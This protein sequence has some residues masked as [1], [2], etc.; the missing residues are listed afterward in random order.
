MVREVILN[1]VTHRDYSQ[2]GEVLI[3]HSLHE[4][5]V[6][7]PGGFIGGI[8]LR[9]ILRHEPVARNRTLANAFLKLRLVES[10]RYWPQQNIHSDVAIRETDTSV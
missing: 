4:L 3:R 5:A 10:S 6:T 1:A 9:N 8:T 7:S 2:P